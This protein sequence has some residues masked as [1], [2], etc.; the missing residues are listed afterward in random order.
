M[1]KYIE[2]NIEEAENFLKSLKTDKF[3]VAIK[4]LEN[5]NDDILGRASYNFTIAI[6][7]TDANILYYCEFDT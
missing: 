7:D 5:E 2:L 6:Y 1:I 4:N 3:L